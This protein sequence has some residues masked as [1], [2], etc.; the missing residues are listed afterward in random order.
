M[1]NRKLSILIGLLILIL[2]GHQT[3]FSVDFLD[4]EEAGKVLKRFGEENKMKNSREWIRWAEGKLLIDRFRQSGSRTEEKR[5][6]AALAEWNKSEK[7]ETKSSI[8]ATF[9]FKDRWH[10]YK[11]LSLTYTNLD[12]KEQAFGIHFELIPD[13]LT[14]DEVVRRY[15]RDG[16]EVVDQGRQK[17]Y[18]YAISPGDSLKKGPWRHLQ[19]QMTENDELWVDF[20]LKDEKEVESVEVLTVKANP[21]RT[22]FTKNWKWDDDE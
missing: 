21:Y 5:E 6:A 13:S 17:T 10:G 14:V 4:W 3:A 22:P 2:I 7:E 1:N 9:S 11:Y 15:G 12:F 8:T 19:N 18:R 20:D 16:L